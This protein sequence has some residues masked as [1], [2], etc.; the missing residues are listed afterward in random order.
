MAKKK[1][2]AEIT[3]NVSSIPESSA[4]D[5]NTI[6]VIKSSTL[7]ETVKSPIL[8]DLSPKSVS[9]F[10]RFYKS[11]EIT[12][13]IHNDGKRK[14]LIECVD[15]ILMDTICS[16]LIGKSV[17]NITDEDLRDALEKFLSPSQVYT[18]EDFNTFFKGVKMDLK[19]SDPRARCA[20][21]C[22]KVKSVVRDHRLNA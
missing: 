14:T 16:F 11:Y 15:P 1:S 6:Q 9:Q 13:R 10:F 18:E 21:Y 4:A 8:K 2:D 22:A 3:T 17:D 7:A 20:D 12:T 19:I 5:N